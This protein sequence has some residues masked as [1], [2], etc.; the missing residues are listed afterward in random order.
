MSLN[1]FAVECPPLFLPSDRP[2]YDVNVEEEGVA[3]AAD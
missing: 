2:E 3:V 1:Q